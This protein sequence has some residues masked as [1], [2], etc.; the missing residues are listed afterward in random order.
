MTVRFSKR[1]HF[2]GIESAKNGN[3]VRSC[4]VLKHYWLDVA[5]SIKS[6]AHE[7]RGFWFGGTA[8]R[9]MSIRFGWFD[10]RAAIGALAIL[11]CV[12]GSVRAGAG[13]FVTQVEDDDG[14]PVGQAVVALTP[15]DPTLLAAAPQSAWAPWQSGVV[16]QRD[17]TFFPYVEIIARGGQVT[18]RN[19]D[20]PQ[21]HVYSFSPV[22]AFEFVLRPGA[23]SAPVVFDKPGVAAIGCNIH[24]EMIAYIYVTET[25]WIALTDRNGRAQITN[26]PHGAFTTKIWHPAQ[27]PGKAGPSQTVMISDQTASVAV[28]L[29][30]LPMRRHDREHGLY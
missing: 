7:R 12:A 22:K 18:F 17:E 1:H 26:L 6:S 27:R 23:T 21:H 5:Y 8:R 3:N 24:D 25:P 28:K 10:G 11:A 14:R 29:A 16:D 19:S 2:Y 13:E 15:V 20:E 4:C 30:L 9:L